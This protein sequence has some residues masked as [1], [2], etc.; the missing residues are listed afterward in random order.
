[1]RRATSAARSVRWARLVEILAF[2]R[3]RFATLDLDV[4]AT[5]EFHSID[6]GISRSE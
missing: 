1:M 6:G 5:A 3:I 2:L 4:L